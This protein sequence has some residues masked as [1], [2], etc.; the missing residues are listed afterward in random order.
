MHSLIDSSVSRFA[1][2]VLSVIAI[3]FLSSFTHCA[4]AQELPLERIA[5]GSCVKQD[6]PQPIWDSVIAY[7]PQVFLMIGDNIYGDTD[8][9]EIL[10]LKYNMLGADPG[11]TRLRQTCPLLAVWDDHDYGVNDGGREYSIREESQRI[12]NDFFQ[13]PL[14]SPRRSRP[15]IY[16]SVY[17]GPAGRRVQVILLD[18]R[19]FRSP[20]KQLPA[21][22]RQGRGPYAADDDP[23]ATMLGEEQWAWLAEELKRPAEI[24]IIASSI[25]VAA[26]EHGWEAWAT[27]PLERQKLM[28]VIRQ[29]GARG[30]LMI[31]GDRHL[32]ELSR[33]EPQESQLDY[34]LYDLTSSSINQPSGGGNE[35]ETNTRRVGEHYLEVNFGTISIQW[36]ESTEQSPRVTLAIHALDGAIVREQI[37]EESVF[38]T[39]A[40]TSPNSR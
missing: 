26:A 2:F 33:I 1:R 30:V 16:D 29:S 38:A 37:V 3:C 11:F 15:G 9:P 35:S 28:E 17:F 12:F 4:F 8:D 10:K 20:L 22:E 5:F 34:P 6:R 24:R 21:E 19:Y 23:Q 40:T 14:D 27:M 32:A 13:V 25:Q 7:R 18:T 36:P 39:P 31:S